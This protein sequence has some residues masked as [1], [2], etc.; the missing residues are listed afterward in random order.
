M[1]I[2]E[3]VL[4]FRKTFLYRGQPIS[5]RHFLSRSVE[6]QT[7]YLEAVLS[8]GK[9]IPSV[10]RYDKLFKS[11]RTKKLKFQFNKIVASKI[12]LLTV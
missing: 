7:F 4:A 10:V 11:L 12:L 1:T 6:F 2:F 3:T 5:T 8:R 9:C